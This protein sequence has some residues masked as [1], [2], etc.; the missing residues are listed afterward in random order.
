MRADQRQRLQPTPDVMW[1]MLDST[2]DPRDRALLATAMNTGLRAGEITAL[3]V[4]A[5]DLEGLT[6]RAWI[7]KSRLEDDLPM[8]SDLTHELRT[9]LS[10]Y[11]DF[12]AQQLDRVI[13]PTDYL[14]PGRIGP[15][16]RWRTL[17]DGSKQRCHAPAG[18]DPLRPVQKVHK[19]AQEAL[20]KVGLETRHQGIR[21]LRRS[22]ARALF[23]QLV[24]SGHDGA[25]RVTRCFLHHSNGSTTETYLGLSSERR[26]RDL[27]LRGR[28]LLGPQP[29]SQTFKVVPIQKGPAI[30]PCPES[31]ASPFDRWS[32]DLVAPTGCSWPRTEVNCVIGASTRPGDGYAER[33]GWSHGRASTTCITPTSPGSY[34]RRCDGL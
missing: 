22:A 19:I 11:R 27:S 23:D 9:W 4:G 29:R 2:S 10:A 3:K 17:P 14:F 28:S 31:S 1:Q 30:T 15:Q 24:E 18:L 6:L 21:T 16:Y 26:T 32:R 7:S 5:V 12:Q 20:G 33:R 8:P 34:L 25:L 13:K